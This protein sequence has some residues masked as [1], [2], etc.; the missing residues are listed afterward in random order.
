MDCGL[1]H[2]STIELQDGP[3]QNLEDVKRSVS[4]H[5]ALLTDLKEDKEIMQ[6]TL[7]RKLGGKKKVLDEAEG[8]I[9]TLSN[10]WI[11]VY[12]EEDWQR[13][14]RKLGKWRETGHVGLATASSAAASSS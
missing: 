2:V 7:E 14:I 9:Y 6:W 3:F 1:I 11:Q 10:I 5:K 13:V 12:R 8:F 4:L